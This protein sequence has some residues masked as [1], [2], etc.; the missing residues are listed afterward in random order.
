MSDAVIK[1]AIKI[2]EYL[3]ERDDEMLDA[4]VA[5]CCHESL[6]WA[7]SKKDRKALKTVRKYYQW[8]PDNKTWKEWLTDE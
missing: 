6:S 3:T 4:L 1:R 8:K 7:E 5:I 2:K